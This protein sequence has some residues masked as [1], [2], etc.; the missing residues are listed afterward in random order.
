MTN[1]IPSSDK[2]DGTDGS[3]ELDKRDVRALTEVHSVLDD[4]GRARDAPDLY[5][6]VSGSGSE[7]MVDLRTESCECADAR[8]RDPD[9]GCKHV[10]RAQFATGARDVPAW[11]DTD[12][13]DD[14]LGEH[15]SG[16]R[17]AATDGG[18]DIIDAGDDAEIVDDSDAR[19]TGPFPEFNKYGNYTGEDY[20]RCSGC[21][22]EALRR[23]D[24][25]D[26]CGR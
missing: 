13:L 14:Q 3:T 19:I 8:H 12:G 1:Y 4:V 9:G 2:A 24:L 22:A 20:W 11:V 23:Q 6:V 17:V 10:R 16:A 15:V 25:G 5:L 18:A 7:Y 26:C 21:G